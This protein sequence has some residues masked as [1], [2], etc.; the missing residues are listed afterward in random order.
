M[1]SEEELDDFFLDTEEPAEKN[2]T[3]EIVLSLPDD[4]SDKK[5]ELIEQIKISLSDYKGIRYS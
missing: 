3:V 2:D 5:Q 4:L 1:P